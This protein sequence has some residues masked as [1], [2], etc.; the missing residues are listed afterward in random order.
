MRG[1]GFL[2][3]TGA[4]AGINRRKMLVPPEVQWAL[5]ASTGLQISAKFTGSA[6][7]PQST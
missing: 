7:I 2:F 1:I 3:P 5:E 6:T 4:D